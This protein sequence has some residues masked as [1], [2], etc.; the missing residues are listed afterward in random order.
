MGRVARDAE[1]DRAERDAMA[2][3]KTAADTALQAAHNEVTDLREAMAAQVDAFDRAVQQA[4]AEA[5]ERFEGERAESTEAVAEAIG[6]AVAAKEAARRLAAAAQ[7]LVRWAGPANA[8]LTSLRSQKAFLTREARRAGERERAL[9]RALREQLWCFVVSTSRGVERSA[10]AL[11]PRALQGP[12]A[13][14]HLS[15][16]NSFWDC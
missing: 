4:A 2:E 14:S 3:A 16:D 5:A 9:R 8:A 6:S 7:V 11:R 1:G 12:S 10:R 15:G 13:S